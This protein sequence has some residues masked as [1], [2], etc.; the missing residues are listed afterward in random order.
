MKRLALALL[1]SAALTAPVA[2]EGLIMS[3]PNLTFPDS[4]VTAS[5]K[6][7]ADTAATCQPQE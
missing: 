5:T 6:D 3:L 4:D 1:A 2:A 7:C